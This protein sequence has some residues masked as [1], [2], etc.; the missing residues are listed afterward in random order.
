[1]HR[2]ASI[3]FLVLPLALVSLVPWTAIGLLAV[4]GAV[5][6]ARTDLRRRGFILLAWAVT[7]CAALYW[8]ALSSI[9]LAHFH[10][11]FAV[12]LWWFWRRRAGGF[13]RLFLGLYISATAALLLWLLLSSNELPRLQSREYLAIF[14]A[15]APFDDPRWSHALIAWFAFSQAV[16][17]GIWLRL[18]PDDDRPRPA[19]R[20]F[21]HSWRA[22]RLDLGP[23]L[24][25]CCVIASIALAVWALIDLGAARDGY[26]RLA[27]FH[28]HLELAAAAWLWMERPA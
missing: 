13:H 10:N 9:V 24:L 14:R 28:G 17:Y 8:R 25:G 20:T 12:V 19:P 3:W 1:L 6:G 21:Q 23:T 18:I 27:L 22:L 26:L 5:L 7:T 4:L 16:H 2:R 11:V 15:L